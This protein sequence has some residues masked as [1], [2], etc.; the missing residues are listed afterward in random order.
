MCHHCQGSQGQDQQHRSRLDV[1]SFRGALMWTVRFFIPRQA[2]FVI[3]LCLLPSCGPWEALCC[4]PFHPVVKEPWDAFLHLWL[5]ANIDPAA[6]VHKMQGAVGGTL[7]EWLCTTKWQLVCK[8]IDDSCL[9][10]ANI[11]SNVH[12]H[13]HLMRPALVAGGPRRNLGAEAKKWKQISTLTTVF[14]RTCI[15]AFSNRLAADF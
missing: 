9:L 15:C 13:Q 6:P 14:I 7:Q 10:Q 4:R 11:A 5:L 1:D 3:S 8:M 12:S 2:A